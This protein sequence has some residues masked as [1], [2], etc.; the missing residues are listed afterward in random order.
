MPFN[1]QLRA[2]APPPPARFIWT[3]SARLIKETFE[4]AVSS[5]LVEPVAIIGDAGVGKTTALTHLAGT[6]SRVAFVTVTPTNRRLK[7][8]LA[9]AVSAFA[10]YTDAFYA[11]DLASVLEYNLPHLVDA[12]WSL[13]VD[14]VQLLDIEAVFQLC[15]YTELFNLPLVLAGNS[16]ALKRTRA[17]ASAIEQVRNR[18]GRWVVIDGVSADDIREFAVD[19]NVEGR[20]AHELIVH[21][22]RQASFAKLPGCCTRHAPLRAKSDQSGLPLWSTRSHR[23]TA[24]NA[25]GKFSTRRRPEP[26]R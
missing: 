18:I 21:Y 8:M 14:E 11:A 10:I 4:T 9:M 24:R 25:R 22:G 1:L 23:C 26:C 7:A 12:G 16:H 2:L 6:R 3:A 5:P 13:I 19:A 20:D 17:N 15:K